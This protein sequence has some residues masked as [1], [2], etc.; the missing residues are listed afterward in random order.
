MSREINRCAAVVSFQKRFTV[1]PRAVRLQQNRKRNN[2]LSHC[3]RVI[4]S[5]RQIARYTDME[6]EGLR[7]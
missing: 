1:F 7:I 5:D 6:T 3:D 4:D 2:G